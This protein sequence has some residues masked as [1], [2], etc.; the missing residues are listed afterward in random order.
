MPT[1]V[2]RRLGHAALTVLVVSIV[3][4]LL[5]SLVG[6]PVTSILGVGANTA[7]RAAL[8]ERLGLNL[9]YSERFWNFLANA[10]HGQFGISYATQLPV[11]GMLLERLPASLELALAALALSLGLGIPL[12]VLTAIHPRWWLARLLL[13][14]S[15]LGVSVPTF[16]VGILM[17][18]VFAVTLGWLPS[19]GR[20]EV[21]QLGWWS[22]GFLSLSG[23]KSLIMP[24]LTLA[25]G[26]IALVAR[27]VRAEMT[28]VLRMEYIRFARTRGLP[29]RTIHLSHALRNTLIPIITVS[30]IQLGF[31]VG[32]AVVVEA[33]FQWP[34][35]GSLFLKSIERSDIPVLL[36]FLML[37]AI[38]FAGINLLVDL[39]YALIDPRLRRQAADGAVGAL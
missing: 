1:L 12:G 19:F 34:G 3:A 31:L 11:A 6:D 38:F 9:A 26:Q 10:L 13:A 27:L 25:A 18:F 17:I 14:G 16:I 7:D 21:V 15:I 20:G 2:I 23:L 39:A 22:T 30:G 35:I 29:D 28:D 36:A 32:F 8:A 24:A 5:G 4:F 37:A 33:V